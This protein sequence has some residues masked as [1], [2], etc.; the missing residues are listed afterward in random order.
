MIETYTLCTCGLSGAIAELRETVGDRVIEVSIGRKAACITK[1]LV[2]EE[3]GKGVL[4]R[5]GESQKLDSLNDLGEAIAW[6]QGGS[7]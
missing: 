3:G 7:D 4:D 2:V 5:V 1:Y 6:L